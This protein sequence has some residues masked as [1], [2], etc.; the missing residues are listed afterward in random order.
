MRVITRCERRSSSGGGG[1]MI[2]PSSSP[3]NVT[4]MITGRRPATKCLG[5]NKEEKKEP[6]RGS[7]LRPPKT[8]IT[9]RTAAA[10][11][12]A[13]RRRTT[14]R[15]VVSCTTTTAAAAAVPAIAYGV[16]AVSGKGNPPAPA[17]NKR[18][19]VENFAVLSTH[20][21]PHTFDAHARTFCQNI[22]YTRRIGGRINVCVYGTHK[23]ERNI[24][25]FHNAPRW[26]SG[27]RRLGCHRRRHCRPST[28]IS[29]GRCSGRRVRV[30][31]RL[32]S[33]LFRNANDAPP[34]SIIIIIIAKYHYLYYL[35]ELRRRESV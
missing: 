27:E 5:E 13:A 20:R 26:Y 12:A 23:R 4:T 8:M 29:H 9:R 32:V 1:P 19:R 31:N 14:T 24:V 28:T 3:L 34:P 2:V 25:C 10:A 22:I 33:S 11:A 15:G 6:T 18:R 35:H 30:A 21:R 17:A 16:F 7:R